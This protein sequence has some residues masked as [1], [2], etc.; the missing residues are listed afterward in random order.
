VIVDVKGGAHGIADVELL[1]VRGDQDRNRRA[2]AGGE[3]GLVTA[4]AQRREQN[5]PAIQIAALTI[6]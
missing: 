4:L 1:V 6:G 5:A 2:L 3:L